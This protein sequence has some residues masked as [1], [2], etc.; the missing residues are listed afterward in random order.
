MA[1]PKWVFPEIGDVDPKAPKAERLKQ[2]AGLITHPENGRFTRTLVNRIWER[3][4]GR[5]IVHPVDAMHT[6]PWN[7]DLLDYLAVRFADDEYDLH[8]LIHFIMSSK[9]YQS[10]TVILASEPG[11][12]YTYA[13]PIAKRMTAEQ[14]LDS[15]WQIT[16]THPAKAEAKA[17]RKTSAPAPPVRAALVK[18]NFLMRSLGRPHR[19]QVVTTRPGEL[20]TLQ[21]IDLSN[22][23]ILANYLSGG[24]KALVTQGKSSGEL[25]EWLYL[26]ALSRPPTAGER[27][28]LAEIVGDG[29][30]PV[31]VEDMLW[32]VF[33]LPEFQIIR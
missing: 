3:L 7:E 12:D 20:T 5:G 23:E 18:N 17:D 33:M 14:L 22:G 13:G 31:A 8:K 9:A 16:G 32:P 4:M 24:A 30:D 28:V 27:T 10:R 2:L 29:R 21:A 11:E 1:T 25:I 19:D 15:I 6:E 26:Y